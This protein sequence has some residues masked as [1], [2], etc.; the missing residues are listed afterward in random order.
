[1]K[2]INLLLL[3]AL[4]GASPLI[5]QKKENP[6]KETP[7]KGDEKKSSEP[8]D[9]LLKPE[10]YSALS[11]RNIGPA[12]TSGRVMD[13]AVNPKNKSE[14]F[15]AAAAGGVFK[16]QNAGVTFEPIFD[17]QGAYSIGCLAIDRN[18]TN[19]I[20]VGSGENNNQRAVGYG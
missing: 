4:L 16:T 19:I 5:S 3:S 12:V 13:I 7:K 14:W 8:S 17:G 2:K 11:F 6:K 18:N 1:M 10:T 9:P 15:I 20:W